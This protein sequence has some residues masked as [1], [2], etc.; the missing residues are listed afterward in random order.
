MDKSSYENALQ[1]LARIFRVQG[2]RWGNLRNLA[3]VPLFVDSQASRII[4]IA[5]LVAWAVWRRYEF[6]DTRY[7]DK[8]VSRFDSEGGVLHGLVHFGPTD[9]N[10]H[11]PACLS[12]AVRDATVQ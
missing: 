5:D 7:F 4:Q 2:T 6:Q 12:R 9:E 10:C 3:E 8:I 1:S 11:C